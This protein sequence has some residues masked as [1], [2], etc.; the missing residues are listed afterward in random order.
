[1]KQLKGAN[2]NYLTEGLFIETARDPSYA[3]YTLKYEDK[4]KYKS[5]YKIYMES[6][7]EYE[8]AM[9]LVGNMDHWK[10]LCSLKWFVEGRPEVGHMGLN[11]W[12][13]HMTLRDESMAKKILME[14]A[15][16]GD[17]AAA[18]KLLDVAKQEKKIEGKKKKPKENASGE[19]LTKVVKQFKNKWQS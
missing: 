18:K 6:V 11:A 13:E 14:K 2:G 8:A 16:Q 10:K 15:Q 4:G 7:D 12:R 17:T 19:D 1:M 5:A 9:K 3:V